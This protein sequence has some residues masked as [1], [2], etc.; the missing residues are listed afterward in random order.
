MT[1]A[2]TKALCLIPARGGSKR[3]PRKNIALL[4]GKPLLAWTIEAAIQ[5]GV[6]EDIWV[7]S[8]DEEICDVA[9]DYGTRIAE[10]PDE[11][12]GDRVTV[13]QVCRQFLE[14]FPNGAANYPGL[15]VMLP[16]SPFRKP[17][18]IR[19][20][21]AAFMES[22]ADSLLSIVPSAHPP[23]W[24]LKEKDGRLYPL[25]PEDYEKPRQEI[26]PS[27]NHDGG[28]AIAKPQL[29]LNQPEFLG[30]NTIPFSVPPEESIDVNE[31]LD[32]EWAEF[33]VSTGR[34]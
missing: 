23:Q 5:S 28:H 8:E 3:F 11:F 7:S 14:T 17:D 12:A 19:R 32:L 25:M 26:I 31:R 6:F 2:P 16:T 18:T 15:Y 4:A 22:G 21:W 1:E 33:L 29:F 27:F 13:V 10:R 9:R 34:V 24:A 30:S 20:A